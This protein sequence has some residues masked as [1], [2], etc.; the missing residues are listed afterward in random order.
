[1]RSSIGGLT[2]LLAAGCATALSA[3]TEGRTGRL[4]IPTVS[5]IPGGTEEATTITGDLSLPPGATGRVPAV[6]VLHSCAGMTPNL[7][8]WAQA[9]NGMGFAAMVLDSFSARGVTEICTGRATV[10]I[11][12][13]LIDV[14]RALALLA[15]H[16]RIDPRRIAVLGFSHGGW[17]A[18][19]ASQAQM[20][21]RF[22]R[23]NVEFAAH[24]AFYPA[25]CNVLL[26]GET[27]MTPGPVRIF[28]GTADD[29]TPIAACRDWVARRRAAGRDVSL[30]AYEGAMHAFDVP[31]FTPSRRWSG[32]FNAGGCTLTEQPDRTFVADD[33]RPLTGSSPCVTR[34]ATVGYDAAAHRQSIADV[35]GFLDEAFRRR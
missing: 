22:L 17:V 9:V 4:E 27:D 24:A 29:W 10:S 34:G 20:E 25:A 7:V 12:S 14:Y 16:P 15:S 18:L 13:R 33:G 21:R 3:V 26:L 5:V 31:F 23:A 6:I 11:S 1:V 8:D 35:H 2:L 30:V 32:V 19:W 28:H